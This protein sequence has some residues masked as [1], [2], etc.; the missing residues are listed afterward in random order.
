M[1]THGLTIHKNPITPIDVILNIVQ[2][3]PLKDVLH[4]H[5]LSQTWQRLFNLPELKPPHRST[6]SHP[7]HS[8]WNQW[9]PTHKKSSQDGGTN[10]VDPNWFLQITHGDITQLIKSYIF[11]DLWWYVAEGARNFHLCHLGHS[12]KGQVKDLCPR[13]AIHVRQ[14][15]LIATGTNLIPYSG[16]LHSIINFKMNFS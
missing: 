15:S 1:S 3:L 5:K 13:S 11:D 2:Y 7:L 9:T 12:G 4:I 10:T 14:W 16:P 8:Q 6:S